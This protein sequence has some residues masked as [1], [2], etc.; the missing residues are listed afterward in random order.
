MSRTVWKNVFVFQDCLQ[1]D[2]QVV[3]GATASGTSSGN[4]W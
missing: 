1:K 2:R 3:R 4:E